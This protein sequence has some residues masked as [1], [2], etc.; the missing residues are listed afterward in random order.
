MLVV[1]AVACVQIRDLRDFAADTEGDLPVV[2]AS[3]ADLQLM[4][5]ELRSAAAA[6]STSMSGA[7]G[8]I[9]NTAAALSNA[10][11][12]SQAE[13]ADISAGGTSGEGAGSH[14]YP[15]FI[16]GDNEAAGTSE[17]SAQDADADEHEAVAAAAAAA[18]AAAAAAAGP[19]AIAVVTPADSAL[20]PGT[21]LEVHADEE[22]LHE[23]HQLVDATAAALQEQMSALALRVDA[24]AASMEQQQQQAVHSQVQTHQEAAQGASNVEVQQQQQQVALTAADVATKQDLAGLT[25]SLQV[26]AGKVLQLEGAL[27]SIAG[28]LSSLQASAVTRRS[29]PETAAASTDVAGLSEPGHAEEHAQAAAASSSEP[30]AAAASSQVAPFSSS[31]PAAVA[32]AAASTQVALL[33]RLVD[34]VSG[35]SSRLRGQYAD[36][37]EAEGALQAVGKGVNLQSGNG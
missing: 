32:A 8:D 24:L 11:G 23:L 22:A 30:P 15:G 37:P 19:S 6:T 28:S 9:S 36:E 14:Q 25:S 20:S 3:V 5:F 10:Q 7:Q 26:V 12:S 17:P 35:T 18:G 16:S 4:V 1:V 33:S 31:E 2:K 34:V 21:V 29:A 27:N 13:S